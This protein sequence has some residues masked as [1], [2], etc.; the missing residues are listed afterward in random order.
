MKEEQ[1]WILRLSIGDV[2]IGWVNG[3]KRTCRVL[4][5]YLMVD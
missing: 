5:L 1:K 2:G 3:Y 4:Q